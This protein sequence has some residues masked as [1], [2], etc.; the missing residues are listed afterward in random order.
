[1][2]IDVFQ[3]IQ[4][5]EFLDDEWPKKYDLKLEFDDIVAIIDIV[6]NDDRDLNLNEL[7]TDAMETQYLLKVEAAN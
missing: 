7:A 4:L 2:K 6:E 5:T 1:M 3:Q